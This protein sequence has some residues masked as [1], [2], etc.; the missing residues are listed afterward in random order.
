[1]INEKPSNTIMMKA[2]IESGRGIYER[3][4]P[5]TLLTH[6]ID[7]ERN[8]KVNLPF[9]LLILGIRCFVNVFKFTE[10]LRRLFIQPLGELEKTL[11]EMIFFT[12]KKESKTGVIIGQIDDSLAEQVFIDFVIFI[13][14][15]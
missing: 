5:L 14:F 10:V 4:K 12:I 2:S 6:P 13:N 9:Y 3:N 8:V 7:I 1:M 15:F 11:L